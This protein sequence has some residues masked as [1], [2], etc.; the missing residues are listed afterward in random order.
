M[1]DERDLL[2]AEYALGLLDGDE[3]AEARALAAGDAAFRAEA[4][5]WSGDLAPLLDEVAAVAPP[6]GVWA[7]IERK[8]GPAPAN[9]NALE[10]RLKV[11]RGAALGA[12]AL[13]ASLAMYVVS[14]PAILSPP[15]ERAATAP[16]VAMLGDDKRDMML[17]AS[18]DPASRRLMVAA[19]SDLPPDPVHAHQLWMIPADGKPRSLGTMPGPKMR[20]ELPMPMAREFREGVTL[21]LSVEPMGGSPTGQP[22]GPVVASGKLERA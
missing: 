4:A 14:G 2:A 21:A 9:D 13:A 1:S 8:L 22:T 5:R 6:S 11:W 19:A 20:A 15:V 12:G 17:V 3:L 16:L 10:R 18:F 7:A